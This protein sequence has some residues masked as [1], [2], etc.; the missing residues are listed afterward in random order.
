M[1]REQL[2]HIVRAAATIAG[3]QE[4]LILGSQSILGTFSEDELPD[5]A[6]ASI[7][8][9]VTFFR[10]YDNDKSDVVD[11]QIGEDSHFHET[12]GYYAQGVNLE[13][14]SLPAGWQDRTVILE[15]AATNG[16][17]GYCLEPHDL[18]VA[19]LVA[20]RM[21]DLKFA[22]ALL[23]AGLIDAQVL[24]ERARLLEQPTA[25]RRVSGW[26]AGWLAK[27]G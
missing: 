24:M 7:E 20:G 6:Y 11:A 14:A 18:V 2:E 5:A 23:H 19:K 25:G 15:S 10:D 21:K 16:A 12:H 13:V 22:D 8:A 17:R 3:D 27:H 4:V 26:V 1:K 9:D